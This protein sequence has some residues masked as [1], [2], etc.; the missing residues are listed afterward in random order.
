MNNQKPLDVIKQTGVIAILRKIS[1]DQSLRVV[2]ALAKAGV[3]AVEV[4]FNTPDAGRIIAA[5]ATRFA[6]SVYPGAGTVTEPSQVIEAKESGAQFILAP[7]TDEAV[8]R[9]AQQAGLLMT[10]GAFTPSEV[11]QCA[12]LG[13]QLIKLFPVSSAGPQYVK[14]LRG[15]FDTLNF[16]PVG[17][18][19]LTNA[20]AFIKAGA[21]AV[22]VGGGL[23]QNEM[24]AR[25]DYAAVT[26]LGKRFLDAIA[27][28]RS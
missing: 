5:I 10:P 24:L 26:D 8:I 1:Q 28:A 17:G 12:R 2:E 13:C 16:L 22:G 15:P 25:G 23:V 27:S 7:N 18:V 6:G 19:D 14:D 11:A 4:T 20:A 21:A 3:T 9:M